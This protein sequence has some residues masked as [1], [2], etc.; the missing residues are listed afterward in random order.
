ML[1][2]S[3][4]NA[5]L[6]ENRLSQSAHLARQDS[7]RAGFNPGAPAPSSAPQQAGWSG[8]A[9]FICGSC[10]YQ[11]PI[12]RNFCEM[13]NARRPANFSKAA[14]L[15]AIVC[16]GLLLLTLRVGKQRRRCRA[17]L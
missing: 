17:N 15:G 8:A 16:C 6:L 10:T 13:C 9:V 12:T 4:A 3:P 5:H 2:V 11:N 14:R 1:F 7:K